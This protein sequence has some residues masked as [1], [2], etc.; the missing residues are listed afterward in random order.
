ML[1][2]LPSAKTSL[3]KVDPFHN[4]GLRFSLGAFRSSSV[5]SLYIEAHESPL[6]IRREKLALQYIFRLK[7]NPENPACDVVFNLKHPDLYRN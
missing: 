5:E 4:Q 2:R 3:A 1:Y 6:E 7:H